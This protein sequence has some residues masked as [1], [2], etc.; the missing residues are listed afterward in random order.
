MNASD[1]DILQGYHYID[2][3]RALNL[4]YHAY[5]YWVLKSFL[6]V[7]SPVQVLSLPRYRYGREVL[8]SGMD[9]DWVLDGNIFSFSIWHC[10]S[11][12]AQHLALYMSSEL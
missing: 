1:D 5:S 3:V 4:K 10:N 12:N 6:Q 8:L 7:Q 11:I 2:K 9:F